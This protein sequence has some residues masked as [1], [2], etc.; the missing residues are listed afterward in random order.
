MTEDESI[1]HD[2][3]QGVG[4]EFDSHGEPHITILEG[5]RQVT[6]KITTWRGT[7]I[8]AVHWYADLEADSLM[9]KKLE[10]GQVYSMS[11]Y[12]FPKEAEG[13]THKVKT[14]AKA[15]IL[16]FSI[17]DGGER[18]VDVKKGQRTELLSTRKEAVRLCK[19]DFEEFFGEGWVLDDWR[20]ILDYE[21]E[22]D[23]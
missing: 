12:S 5:L 14:V 7:S 4:I 11:G 3:T 10:T 22:D 21:E 2:P 6:P 20:H 17:F 16:R 1:R 8:G 19:E 23:L 18:H 9:V 13:F 15:D